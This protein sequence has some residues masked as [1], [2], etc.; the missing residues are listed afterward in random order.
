MDKQHALFAAFIRQYQAGLRAFVRGLGV[1]SHAVDDIAQEAFLVAYRQ[2]DKFDQDL[3]FGNWL[4]GIARNIV[5][6][7]LRKNARQNRIMDESLSHFL[8]N[9]FEL[10]YE[11]SDYDGDEVKALTECISGLPDKSRSLIV[12]KYSEEQNTQALSE[13]FNMTA[14]AIRLALMR[15]RNKL[16]ACVDYRLGYE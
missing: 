5:R 15:I 11:P 8:I 12:K 7:E 2:L 1:Q 9:E 4:R 14:T 16:K 13:Q 3:D 10:N 6:N